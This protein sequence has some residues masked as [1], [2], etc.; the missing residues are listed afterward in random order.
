MHMDAL[1]APIRTRMVP[2]SESP[3]PEPC[4]PIERSSERVVWAGNADCAGIALWCIRQITSANIYGVDP[5]TQ[6]ELQTLVTEKIKLIADQS[7]GRA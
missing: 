5:Q 6:D 2:L 7:C 1:T 3:Y 4:A